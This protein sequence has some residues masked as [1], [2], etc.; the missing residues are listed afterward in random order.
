MADY[1]QI[2][3]DLNTPSLQYRTLTDEDVAE[4]ENLER[5][6][7]LQ[8]ERAKKYTT[9]VRT[10]ILNEADARGEFIRKFGSLRS[11]VEY[12]TKQ[13]YG[14]VQAEERKLQ[15][16]LAHQRRQLRGIYKQYRLNGGQ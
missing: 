16:L 13:A 3:T 6:S 5:N 15:G 4:A 12:R 2:E 9:A 8:L 1:K 10:A 7:Q 14:E 11:T